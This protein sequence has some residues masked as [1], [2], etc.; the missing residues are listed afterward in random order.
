MKRFKQLAEELTVPIRESI[1]NAYREKALLSEN[2]LDKPTHSPESL[3]KK[4]NVPVSHIHD[5]LARGI[6][7]E[8]EHTSKLDV[9]REIALDHLGERPDYYMKLDKAGLEEEKR[10]T[11]FY[12][13][14][15]AERRRVGITKKKFDYK[16]FSKY[17]T[18][19]PEKFIAGIKE[20]LTPR[21]EQSHH[22]RLAT[23]KRPPVDQ[24]EKQKKNLTRQTNSTANARETSAAHKT[25]ITGRESKSFSQLGESSSPG[26]SFQQAIQ[27]AK[28]KGH[29][30]VFGTNS[31]KWHVIDQKDRD[32]HMPHAS[33]PHEAEKIGEKQSK[34]GAHSVVRATVN[35][36]LE[37]ASTRRTFYMNQQRKDPAK[38]IKHVRKKSRK[39]EEPRR[40]DLDEAF[41]I[42]FDESG[43]A[44]FE[45]TFCSQ[46]GKDLGPGEHGASDCGQHRR[47]PG[48]HQKTSERRIA[49]FQASH[50]GINN[51]IVQEAFQAAKDKKN[52]KSEKQDNLPQNQEGA[53]EPNK[54][55]FNAPAPQP[56]DGAAPTTTQDGGKPASAIPTVAKSNTPTPEK[57]GR[58]I[59]VKG[60]GADDKFQSEPIYTSLTT[61]PDT[62]SPRSG[63]QGVR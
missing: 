26:M 51:K 60:S 41:N 12:N 56:Q 25:V 44:K 48:K 55:K 1:F 50:K 40:K 18:K 3:A 22:E 47:M 10:N 45:H 30:I 20:S 57:K 36:K 49:A 32:F 62:A 33:E 53:H 19:H 29:K 35:R 23:P 39:Y 42:A 4:Y 43:G 59:D 17:R 8:Q 34:W 6:K 11:S 61:M 38:F 7:I 13:A 21:E 58:K 15:A 54:E 14:T 24:A 46:C 52:G 5:Q 27:D 16:K 9:A 31:Q 37:E 28:A 63:S 2:L